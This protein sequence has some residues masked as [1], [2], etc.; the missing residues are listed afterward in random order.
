MINNQRLVRLDEHQATI[1]N[2]IKRGERMLGA[3]DLD[4]AALARTR[5]ELARA[6]MMYQGFK[7]RE[8]LDPISA[9][10][11]PNRAGAARRLKA[12]CTAMDER[13]RAYIAKWSAVS[14]LDQRADYEPAA[15]AL[16]ADLRTHLARERQETEKLLRE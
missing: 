9:E 3:S 5:W 11:C 12:E 16:I 4:A 6:L 1:L 10:T 15:L 14:V 2:I 7:H 8:I 13:F